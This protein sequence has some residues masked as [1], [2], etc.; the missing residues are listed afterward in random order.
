LVDVI[1]Q[2]HNKVPKVVSTAV[3]AVKGGLL[4]YTMSSRA[5]MTSGVG[6][7]SNGPT[8]GNP[9]WETELQL[10]F[11]LQGMLHCRQ[12]KTTRVKAAWIFNNI[13]TRDATHSLTS[14]KVGVTECFPI[15]INPGKLIA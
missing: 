11:E 14:G 10:L 6:N 5:E 7:E 9:F 2:H 3:D 13:E 12:R 1:H 4:D 8:K 15:F